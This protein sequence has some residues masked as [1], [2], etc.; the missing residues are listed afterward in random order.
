MSGFIVLRVRAHRALLAAALL[1]VLLTATVLATLSAF[2]DAVGDAGLR[3]AL[4]T[5]STTL[6]VKAQLPPSRRQLADQAVERGAR[7][8]FDGLPHTLR[9]LTRSGP[10]ALPRTLP[11]P[12][13]TGAATGP[14][15]GQE[16]DL[17]HLAALDRSRIT[18]TAG[19]WPGE[20]A[21]GRLP[22]AL[23]AAA[24]ARLGLRPGRRITLDNRLSG[25]AHLTVEVTG[26]YRPKDRTDPYWKLDELG[27]RGVRTLGF[28]TYGPLLT[29]PGAFR[30]GGVLVQDSVAWLATADFPTLTADRLPALATAARPA[31]RALMADPAFGGQ[32]TAATELPEVLAQLQ[33]SLLVNRSTVLIVALQLLL[34]AGYAL[35]LVAR[36]LSAERTGE[37]ALLRAR[38]ASRPQL[39]RLALA[40]ALLL[41]L[42]AA[43]AAPLLAGPLLRLPASG[44]ATGRSG[45]P[46]SSAPAGGTWLTG[47]VVALGCAAAVAAPAVLRSGADGSAARGRTLP[48]AVR[49]GADL[50]LLVVAGVA[51]W[52]LWRRTGEGG[53]GVLS[54]DGGGQLGIDPVLVSAPA[55]ALL[56]GAVLT[57]RLLPPAA[58]LAERAAAR[59]RG[60][61]VAL[62]GWQISRRGS[63]GPPGRARGGAA[64]RVTDPVLL[65]VLATA[66]GMLA[67]GQRASWNRSQDDQADL[68]A[69]AAVRVLAGRTPQ[70]GQGGGYAAVPG[71]A[72]ALPVGNAVLDLP[73]GHASALL[74]LDTRRAVGALLLRGD[75]AGGAA[76]GP[77]GARAADAVL[78]AAA[79]PAGP[80]PGVP[81]PPDTTRLTLTMTLASL[82][83]LPAP[84]RAV[85]SDGPVGPDTGPV[86]A[87]V[88][89]LVT[90][91]HG[92]PYTLPLASLP[93]DG[94]PHT[95]TADLAA[96]AGAP[97]G[98]PAAPLRLTGFVLDLDQPAVAHRQR[99]T[100][101]AA[102]AVT[103]SGA[104][105]RLTAPRGPAW[106]ARIADQS[107]TAGG[108][109]GPRTGRTEVPVGGLLAQTYDSGARQDRWGA[110]LTTVRI[111]A[112]HPARPPLA[113]V[114]TDAFLRARGSRVGA[115]IDVTVN[116][117]SLKARIVRAVRAL[118]GP[119]D[120]PAGSGGLLVDFGAV[121]EA[122]SDVG[123]TPLDAAEWWLRP[124]PGATA[125]AVA[126]LRAR[127][128]LDPG[129]VVV[130]DEIAAELH[131]DPLGRGPQ[132]ALAAAAAVAVALA[133]TGFAVGAAGA[134]RERAREFAVLRALGAPRRQL[135]RMI[136]VEQGVLIVPALAVGTALG[137]VLTR[138]VV[139]LV[140]L[141][142]EAG[143]PVPPVLVELP[144]GQVAGLVAAVAVVPLLV[145][146]LGLRRGDPVHALR[147]QG[148]R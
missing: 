64:H 11:A 129:Q 50:G 111:T 30:S 26:V 2:S 103:G 132:T 112:A 84:R 100:V 1:S 71:V 130:R 122:L 110:A 46:L 137:T 81:L 90:D 41:A 66:L 4:R 34:L 128:D 83:S 120:G 131:E 101:A 18:L 127:A 123:A 124:R 22:V 21:H 146:A 51:Y 31:A 61:V 29:A 62:A 53:G 109:A 138:A 12:S 134:V 52:Q 13:A 33:R 96:A 5:R 75:L 104:T 20:A 121:N 35:L 117:R 74:A 56:A 113:A 24:A 86:P 25:P 38:G 136:A 89:V 65:L 48:G 17:T 3:Q 72:A 76:D 42:P 58:R 93:A 70:L 106:T 145:V 49:A 144:P 87:T 36:M 37:Q 28:T 15:D 59:G 105:H 44:A 107:S 78:R 73:D 79:P 82:R 27:G 94:R 142:Q 102:T 9:T 126:A 8:A 115:V 69:G 140:V 116:G 57:L 148:E 32:V 39:A 98:R 97:A 47:A 60:L 92:S 143:R 77:A 91:A 141:T 43:L 88:S 10:Y 19:H 99:L 55:L 95:G 118:P 114:A 147:T 23:P 67:I 45:L 133:A 125:R 63:A 135:A 40:E 54:V 139:P 80:P 119:A 7:R 16:P 14:A 108:P 85:P 6:Q 68:R